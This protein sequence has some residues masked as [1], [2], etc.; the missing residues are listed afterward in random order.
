VTGRSLGT[1]LSWLFVAY[2]AGFAVM[3][4]V[5]VPALVHANRKLSQLQ[6]TVAPARSANQ[7]LDKALV[8]QET[9]ERGYI[10]TDDTSFLGPYDAGRRQVAVQLSTLRR[11]NLPG[12]GP[13]LT[14]LGQADLAW[15]T[16]A[17]LEIRAQQSGHP[18][19]AVALVKGGA[20]RALFGVSR[21]RLAAVDAQVSAVANSFRSQLR[22]ALGLLAVVLALSLVGL[23]AM[24]VAGLVLV[25]RWIV[26]PLSQLVEAVGTVSDGQLFH[27]M[28]ELS[29]PE[30]GELADSV[31][32]M[33]VEILDQL[34]DA[35]HS[36]EALEQHG[37]MVLQLRDSLAADDVEVPPGLRVVARVEPAEGFL[38][39]D[40]YDLKAFDD[41]RLGLVVVDVAGH[42][43]RPGVLAAQI[44]HLMTAAWAVEPDDPAAA[45]GWMADRLGDTGDLFATA[46][47]VT[48]D[49]AA[50]RL[51]VVNAAH[52]PVL[53]VNH[54]ELVRVGPTGPLVGPFRA[55]WT[56][57][58][59]DLAPDAMVVAY[60]DG[61]TEARD[62]QGRQFGQERLEEI[63]LTHPDAEAAMAAIAAELGSFRGARLDDDLT[64][65]IVACRPA[66]T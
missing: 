22:Q 7:S 58:D 52:P 53:V 1:R 64:I 5:A 47:V 31:D 44:K 38:A 17:Q 10:I 18:D 9:G 20:G 15:Q 13:R 37:P 42:G 36:R 24:T 62:P 28:P 46:A 43:A 57:V 41:G 3:V 48:I 2:F 60:T 32:A 34:R 50:G 54:G 33:R 26:T 11:L 8:D 23:V 49:P 35:V 16:Q 40:F 12:M 51:R 61:L 63:V 29:S 27:P 56:T 25:R 59:L 65:A 39:G 30:L 6:N 4:A 21:Q 55:S 45:V 66:D 14:A 19:Q